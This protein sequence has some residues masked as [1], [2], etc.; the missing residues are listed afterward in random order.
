VIELLVEKIT[1][2]ARRVAGYFRM[3]SFRNANTSA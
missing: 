1:R 3:C 2:A